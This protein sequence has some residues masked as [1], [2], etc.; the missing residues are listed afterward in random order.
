[1][2]SQYNIKL[3]FLKCPEFVLNGCGRLEGR[4]IREAISLVS[5]LFTLQK[6]AT[7]IDIIYFLVF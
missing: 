5:G 1:M 4:R 7:K 3:S 6:T 2:Q